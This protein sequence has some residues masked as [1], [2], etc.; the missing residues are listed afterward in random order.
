M[1]LR[2]KGWRRPREKGQRNFHN[3]DTYVFLQEA[4]NHT[5]IVAYISLREKETLPPEVR[6][7]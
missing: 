5:V 4:P 7:I 3:N 1:E 2:L 6:A